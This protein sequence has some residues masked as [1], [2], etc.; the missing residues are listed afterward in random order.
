M[1]NMYDNPQ[2]KQ[3][4]GMYEEYRAFVNRNLEAVQ[5]SVQAIQ[6]A[7]Q[8]FL[9]KFNHNM[10]EFTENSSKRMVD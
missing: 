2:T 6:Q 1:T 5:D 10:K 9:D 4:L 3:V 7:N 8:N